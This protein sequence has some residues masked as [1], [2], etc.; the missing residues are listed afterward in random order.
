MIARPILIICII[1]FGL[2]S[3]CSANAPIEVWNAVYDS[4]NVDET[5]GITIDNKGNLYVIGHSYDGVDRDC[6]TIKYDNNGNELWSTI[7]DSGIRNDD[8]T[9]E[10]TVDN[11]GNVYVT[12]HSYD[13]VNSDYLTVKYDSEGNNIWSKKFDNRKHDVSYGIAVDNSENVYVSGFSDDGMIDWDSDR[14]NIIIK[15]DK[16][17]NETWSKRI[18]SRYGSVNRLAVDSS[19]NM[20]VTGTGRSYGNPEY[21]LTTKYD[22]EGNEIW[23][24]S[25]VSDNYNSADEIIVDNNG[26]VYV[27][28]TSGFV[29]YDTD[30]NEIWHKLFDISNSISHRIS[31]DDSGNVYLAIYSSS[32]EFEGINAIKYNAEGNELWNAMIDVDY[33][34]GVAVDNIGNVYVVRDLVYPEYR[35][36]DVLTV[37]YAASD[38]KLS[39]EKDAEELTT[40]GESTEESPGFAGIVAIAVISVVGITLRKRK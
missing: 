22:T 8:L 35:D 6:F 40:E 17:G 13:G 10:V 7:F 1:L 27:T 11:S 18:S 36:D 31:V 20:Y 26:N 15:Y 37:K 14:I 32:Y 24:K 12:G 16:D 5:D 34:G 28:G 9:S 29:K 23:N 38:I 33:V 3:I 19:G 21:Y 30:G 25:F 4:E 2:T 39:A